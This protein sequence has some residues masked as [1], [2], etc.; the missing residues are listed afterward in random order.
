MYY[1]GQH[2][3]FYISSQS[4]LSIQQKE[5]SSVN[6][7]NLVTLW[8]L[9][10]IKVYIPIIYYISPKAPPLPVSINWHLFSISTFYLKTTTKLLTLTSYTLE[11]NICY[12]LGKSI[13]YPSLCQAFILHWHSCNIR[14]FPACL[15]ASQYWFQIFLT[16]SSHMIKSIYYIHLTWMLHLWIVLHTFSTNCTLI[17]IIHPA[18]P[19]V[20]IAVQTIESV[21]Y[22]GDMVKNWYTQWSGHFTSP[23]VIQVANFTLN[24][25]SLR[26]QV[27]LI[28][29]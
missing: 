7:S 11:F 10:S 21:Q 28:L 5:A 23:C 14:Y 15:S 24:K 22:V 13:Y 17:I 9:P 6:L 1:S 18:S 19:S 2:L 26:S 25:F 12:Y 20:P 16:F 4:K 29:G 3:W 27:T 8:N